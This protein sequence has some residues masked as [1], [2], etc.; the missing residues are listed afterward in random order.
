MEIHNPMTLRD[1]WNADY[2]S[3]GAL[4]GGA[5]LPLPDL[6]SGALVLDLGCGN[7]KHLAAMEARGW[8]VVGLDAAL[9]AVLIC[10][11]TENLVVGE[12]SLLPFRGATFDAVI[13]IHILGHLPKLLRPHLFMDVERIL[14]IGGTFHCTV[15]SRGDMRCGKGEEIEPF[16]Y[17]RR[18]IITHYFTVEELESLKEPF[19]E[20]IISMVSHEVKISGERFTREHLSCIFRR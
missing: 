13:G 17:S 2:R 7:G 19:S 15:F 8:R 16:T 20:A 9:E 3:R 1:A 5:S 18:G 10:K 11:S 14:K 6:M 4:Y 12:A